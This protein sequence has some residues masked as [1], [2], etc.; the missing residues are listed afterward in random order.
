MQPTLSR[1]RCAYCER[2][3]T[4][5]HHQSDDLGAGLEVLEW[6]AFGDVRTLSAALPRFKR[7]SFDRTS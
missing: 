3:Q 4:T 6:G 1:V 7:S 5:A 2:L